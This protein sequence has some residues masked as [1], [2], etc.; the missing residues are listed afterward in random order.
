MV[1]IKAGVAA[2]VMADSGCG[3]ALTWPAGLWTLHVGAYASPSVT[4]DE[5]DQ[6]EIDEQFS[7]LELTAKQYKYN[8][9]S[10]YLQAAYGN[11]A[12]KKVVRH[13]MELS[14]LATKYSQQQYDSYYSRYLKQFTSM[15]QTMQSMEQT[16]GMF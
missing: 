10:K 8:S 2:A 5:D 11:G 4:L 16:F 12:T 7:Y 1:S 9:V 6:H 14:Q 3:G 15:M 13:M